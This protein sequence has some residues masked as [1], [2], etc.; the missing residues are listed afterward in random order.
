MLLGRRRRT[1]LYPDATAF[2]TA[3]TGRRLWS[4]REISDRLAA[5][6]RLPADLPDVLRPLLVWKAAVEAMHRDGSRLFGDR[7]L[8]IRLEDLRA[9]P[10][11]EL[12]R[13]YG[14]AGAAAPEAV[15]E[16]AERN[17][18]RRESTIRHPGDPRWAAASR[19]IGLEPALDDAG[20]TEIL[21]LGAQSVAPFDLDPPPAPSRLSAML[22]RTRRRLPGR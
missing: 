17:L 20:Y 14:A 18:R 15:V 4:S 10:R 7:Y 19:E 22:R 16:W 12:G 9:E 1:D 5:R 3:R 21:E 11:R 6:E 8:L 2:F 13:L